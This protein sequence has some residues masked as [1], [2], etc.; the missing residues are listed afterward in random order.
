MKK[1]KVVYC[2]INSWSEHYYVDLR[3][4]VSPR[5]THKVWHNL[6]FSEAERINRRGSIREPDR[7][8]VEGE[9]IGFFFDRERAVKGAI[10]TYKKMFPSAVILVEGDIGV[11]EPQPILDGPPEDMKAL[12]ALV[13][14]A[15]ANDHWDNEE[16]MEEITDEWEEIWIPEFEEE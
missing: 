15:E 4:R 2:E 13:E 9:E 14:R 11:Y 1:L 5:R 6:T 10:A 8:F 3:Q 12:N 7:K 16:A